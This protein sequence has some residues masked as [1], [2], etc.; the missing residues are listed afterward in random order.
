VRPFN[1]NRFHYEWHWNWDYGNGDIGNQG[2]HQMDVCRW[3]L[4]KV[5]HPKSVLSVGGRFGYED[6][7]QTANTQV[8]VLDYGDSRIIFEVRG[9]RTDSH[10]GLEVG[11]VFHCEEGYVVVGYGASAAFDPEGKMIQEFHGDGNHWRNFAD[12]VKSGRREELHSDAL[13]GHLSSAPCHLAN[14]SHR[15]GTP[16][17]FSEDRPFG[18]DEEANETFGRFTEH[19][20]ANGVDVS[21][22]NYTLGRRLDF[23]SKGERFV[24]DDEANRM[25]SRDY[26]KPFVVPEQ[27]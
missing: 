17:P 18:D 1:P 6:D 16:R 23:D 10:Y 21:E 2:A 8:A 5:D 3:G 12:A 9:L 22:T 7:G 20:V 13:E 14:I 19:L 25:V 4:N 15:L 11:V 27:V 24:G 26:R